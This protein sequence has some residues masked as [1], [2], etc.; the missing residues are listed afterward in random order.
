VDWKL[1]P[2]ILKVGHQ[3]RQTSQGDTLVE[4]GIVLHFLTK[5]LARPCLKI[6]FPGQALVQGLGFQ[7][8]FWGVPGLT[9]KEPPANQ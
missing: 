5:G 2:G 7:G 3:F 4:N 8:F 9:L 6:E 1:E